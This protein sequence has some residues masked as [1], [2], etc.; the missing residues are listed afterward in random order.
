ML[1]MYIN[2]L[3][4]TLLAKMYVYHSLVGYC[5]KEQIQI[6]RINLTIVHLH[7]CYKS[8][9]IRK[10]TCNNGNHM[11]MIYPKIFILMDYRLVH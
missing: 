9:N 1:K 8:R 4:C 11:D 7:T 6:V 3:L 5:N 2:R 10:L